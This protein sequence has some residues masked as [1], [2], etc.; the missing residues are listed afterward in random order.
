ME[1]LL[2]TET[3]TC[4]VIGVSRS[5]LRKIWAAGELKPVKI[6]RAVRW[7][8]EDVTAYVARL[9]ERSMY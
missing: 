6:G 5:T 8:A 1:N 7:V 2:L 9:R 4:H 3:E